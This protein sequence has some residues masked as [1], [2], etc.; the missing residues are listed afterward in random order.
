MMELNKSM[1]LKFTV[2]NMEKLKFFLNL[3]AT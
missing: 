2:T 1:N 3:E